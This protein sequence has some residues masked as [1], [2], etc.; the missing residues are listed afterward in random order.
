MPRD[1]LPRTVDATPSGGPP[2]SPARDGKTPSKEADAGAAQR[3]GVRHLFA[4]RARIM[5]PSAVRPSAIRYFDSWP[6]IAP[7]GNS[8]V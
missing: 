6:L 1:D 8:A 2:T 4:A 5:R 3:K 7:G